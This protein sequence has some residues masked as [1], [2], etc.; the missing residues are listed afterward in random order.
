[1]S[2]YSVSALNS[3]AIEQ[4]KDYNLG[5]GQLDMRARARDEATVVLSDKRLLSIDE[6][7]IYAGIGTTTAR[8]IAEITGALFRGGHRVLVDRVKFDRYCDENTEVEAV[9]SKTF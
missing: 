9:Y 4:D 5:K 3:R 8:N 2:T 7:C 6:F 1:M